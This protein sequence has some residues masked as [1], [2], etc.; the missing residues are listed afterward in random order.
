MKNKTRW[1]LSAITGVIAV[2]ASYAA[3]VLLCG[4]SPI[5]RMLVL[6]N[7]LTLIP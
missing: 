2:P 5:G 4:P 6:A 1:I 7:A 3:S